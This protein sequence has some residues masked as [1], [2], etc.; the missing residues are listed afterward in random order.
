MEQQL[1][2][3]GSS[4]W[5]NFNTNLSYVSSPYL[6]AVYAVLCVFVRMHS[7]IR[8]YLLYFFLLPAPVKAVVLSVGVYCDV[9]VDRAGAVEKGKSPL[10]G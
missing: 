9:A 6:L 1:P 4:L 8:T 3:P 10:Q 5:R 7:R 2:S